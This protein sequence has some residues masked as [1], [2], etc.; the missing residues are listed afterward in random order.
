MPTTAK[1]LAGNFRANHNIHTAYTSLIIHT[2]VA[3]AVAAVIDDELSAARLA[4]EKARGGARRKKIVRPEISSTARVPS[5]RVIYHSLDRPLG[6][7]TVG[8]PGYNG[9]RDDGHDSMVSLRHM[10]Y[11]IPTRTLRWAPPLVPFCKKSFYFRLSALRF[12]AS[13]RN[14]HL[15]ALPDHD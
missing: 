3:V 13:V 4:R 5:P 6:R 9:C 1:T 15:D 8:R 10:S 12:T 14:A 2:T 7:S 11:R